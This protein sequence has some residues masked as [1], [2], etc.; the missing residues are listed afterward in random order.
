MKL[1]EDYN[2]AYHVIT[3][4]N[5]PV[6]PYRT[7]IY[8]PADLL[9]PSQIAGSNMAWSPSRG[10][11]VATRTTDPQGT[12]VS[13]HTSY[14]VQQQAYGGLSYED[15]GEV[16]ADDPSRQAIYNIYTSGYGQYGANQSQGNDMMS[17]FGSMMMM[18][19]MMSMMKDMKSDKEK[20]DDDD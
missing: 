1:E 18:M 2:P 11:Y 10:G 20:E 5:P 17:G 14:G 7:D 16:V 19:V 4:L 6:R 13:Q 12:V 15:D 3:N 9:G 8:L